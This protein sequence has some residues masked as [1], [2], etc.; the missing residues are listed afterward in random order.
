MGD[1]ARLL[2][3]YRSGSDT[4]FRHRAMWRV[5]SEIRRD[6]ARRSRAHRI[7]G[8]SRYG[9]AHSVRAAVRRHGRYSRRAEHRKQFIAPAQHQFI[10]RRLTL[11]DRI[12]PGAG[13]AVAACLDHRRDLLLRPD[14]ERLDRSVT[15][16]AHP[17]FQGVLERRH[18]GPGAIADALDAAAND[19]EPIDVQTNGSNFRCPA[20]LA[21]FGN[22]CSKEAIYTP[23]SSSARAALTTISM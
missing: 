14:E 20:P 10:R 11:I 3:Q 4:L 1:A 2:A 7:D 5:R 21:R 16:V 23:G 15:P 12:D 18:F 19:Y 9:V 6:L 17:A 22:H 13:R 8:G